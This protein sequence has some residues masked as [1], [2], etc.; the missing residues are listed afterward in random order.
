MRPR[1]RN[2]R[3]TRLT[4]RIAASSSSIASSTITWQADVVPMC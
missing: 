4:S 3:R 1:T 2:L